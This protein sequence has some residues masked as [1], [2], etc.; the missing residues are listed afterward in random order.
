MLWMTPEIKRM[1]LESA[2][3]YQHH[4][5]HGQSIADYQILR[6]INSRCKSAIEEAKSNY[7]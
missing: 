7:F 4:V 3:I 1:V 6:D 2:K 5:K